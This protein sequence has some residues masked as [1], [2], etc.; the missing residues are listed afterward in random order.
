M[1]KK[2][3]EIRVWIAECL[4]PQRHCVLAA[5]GEAPSELGAEPIRAL[6]V[7]QVAELLRAEL[8][9]PWCG[10]CHAPAESWRYELGRTRFASMA[11]AR[12]DMEQNAAEQAI[13]RAVW[14]DLKRSD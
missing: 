14:G 10:L 11:E 7:K 1:R 12:P 13:T 4:C 9:N 8:L 2:M 5:S 6:L 3:A